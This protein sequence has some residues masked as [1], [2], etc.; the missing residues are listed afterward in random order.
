MPRPL[1][2]QVREGYLFFLK[3]SHAR[4]TALAIHQLIG[5]SRPLRRAIEQIGI[6]RA[7]AHGF[8][9]LIS[10][11]YLYVQRHGNISETSAEASSAYNTHLN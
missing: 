10:D 8:Q 11:A 7:I 9:Y 2:Q 5:Q 1:L 6:N 3:K 4:D